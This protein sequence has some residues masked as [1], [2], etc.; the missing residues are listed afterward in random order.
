MLASQSLMYCIYFPQMPSSPVTLYP[1]IAYPFPFKSDISY[2][3]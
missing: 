2:I 1:H 3:G